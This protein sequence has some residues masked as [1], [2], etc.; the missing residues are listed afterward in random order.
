MIR[1]SICVVNCLGNICPCNICPCNICPNLYLRGYLPNFNH[2][3]KIALQDPK[4]F[5]TWLFWSN[6]VWTKQFFRPNFFYSKFVLTP[7]ILMKFFLI[8]LLMTK[9][10]LNPKFFS[11]AFFWVPNFFW[12]KIFLELQFL[13]PKIFFD[14][15]FG[16]NISFTTN[17]IYSSIIPCNLQPSPNLPTSQTNLQL[18]GGLQCLLLGWQIC[19]CNICPCLNIMEYISRYQSNFIQT[20]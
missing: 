6:F 15:F 8:Q 11:T 19:P 9:I 4:T 10:F 5:L 12:P 17:P 13:L 20:R 3:L 18:D 14:N 7:I 2:T 1:S 16:C